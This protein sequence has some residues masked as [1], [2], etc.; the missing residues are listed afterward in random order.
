MSVESPILLNGARLHARSDGA[1]Y[2]P[3]RDTLI[4]ADLHLEK[5]SAYASVTGQMLP[6]YDSRATLTALREAIAAV[7]PRRVICLGDSFHDSDA[8]RRLTAQD[9]NCLSDLTQSTEWIWIA[10]NHDP[11]P[12]AELGG[13]VLEELVDGPLVFRHEA[14][15]LAGAGEVSGHFHPKAS[16]ETRAR[17]LSAR[18]F[19]ED[20]RRL[21]LPS[22]GAYTGGLSVWNPAIADLFPKGFCVHLT[23]RRG[24]LRVPRSRLR[25]VA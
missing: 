12:P 15:P 9:R 7:S 24:V 20:A 8:A 3:D 14:V 17:R 16:I 11:A 21:I 1:L 6:P 25:K 10:G 18:C 22:F 19:V 4:V 2:W 5:G 13:T 23:M